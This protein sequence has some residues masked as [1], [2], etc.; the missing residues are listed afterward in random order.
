MKYEQDIKNYFDQ[1]WFEM[2]KDIA[3]ICSINSERM[4]SKEGMPFGEGPYQALMEFGA[5]AEEKGFAMKTYGNAVGSV[6]LSE[7]PRQLDMLAHLDVVPAGEGWTVTEPFN[8]I[9]KDGKIMKEF[10]RSENLSESSLIKE[11]V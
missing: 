9:M 6:D 1:H 5:M 8:V 3:R 11:M 10:E 7:A 4:E 2:M